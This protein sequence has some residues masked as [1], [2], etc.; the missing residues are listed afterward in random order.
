MTGL[1]WLYNTAPGRVMLKVLAGRKLSIVAGTFLDSGLSRFLIK[2][3]V[4]KNEIDLTECEDVDFKSF[5]DCFTR[6]LKK[7]LRPVDMVKNHLIA[8][9]DGLLSVW[10]IDK[11]TVL[12]I[13]QSAYNIY[14]LFA[15]DRVASYY[16]GGIC[17]VYRLCVNH[18]HRYC[19][20]DSGK[21]SQNVFIPGKLH[22]V[23]PVALRTRPVFVENCR[24]YTLIKSNTFG[25]I[26]QMEVGAM[27]VGKIDNYMGRGKAIRGKEK[28]RFLYG[29]STIIV[30]LKKDSAL[31]NNDIISATCRGEEYPVKMGEQVG[32]SL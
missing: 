23:R 10:D 2:P 21:K 7:E 6:K 32:I 24:E 30:M 25:T 3:F 26:A 9:C 11:D 4:K 28:G 14:D 29:G 22:T 19:Y 8:P 27:L 31:I 16:E 18:Y 20:V 13:K 12:P 5:N 15:S 17:L 1:E